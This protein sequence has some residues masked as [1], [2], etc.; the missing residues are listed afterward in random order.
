MVSEAYLPLQYLPVQMQ[1]H[2]EGNDV[3]TYLSDREKLHFSIKMPEYEISYSM[4]RLRENLAF[5]KEV[6]V[7][8]F[9]LNNPITDP[10]HSEF[11]QHY[12]QHR[13]GGTEVI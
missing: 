11:V 5:E 7:P 6:F 13:L 3:V 10:R 4:P 8:Q 1:N 2:S 9:V 12:L